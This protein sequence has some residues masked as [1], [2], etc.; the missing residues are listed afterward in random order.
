MFYVNNIFVSDFLFFRLYF[1]ISNWQVDERII[2]HQY[3]DHVNDSRELLWMILKF[4][5]IAIIMMKPSIIVIWFKWLIMFMSSLMK[6]WRELWKC[7]RN[8]NGWNEW[9][10]SISKFNLRCTLVLVRYFLVWNCTT[11]KGKMDGLT[12]VWPKCWTY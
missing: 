11:L 9:Y 3:N 10:Q 6:I 4:L 7:P 12:Q 1:V 2:K 8:I 5:R